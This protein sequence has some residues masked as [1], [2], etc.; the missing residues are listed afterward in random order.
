MG[1]EHVLITDISYNAFQTAIELYQLEE[2]LSVII[3]TALRTDK[4]QTTNNTPV[5][6]FELE[7]FEQI[8]YN[9]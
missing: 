1:C 4:V 7:A 8:K 9:K 2:S 5:F 6:P 3:V